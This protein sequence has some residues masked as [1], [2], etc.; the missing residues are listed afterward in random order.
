MRFYLITMTLV[1]VVSDYLLHPFYPQFF[2]LAFGITHPLQ[3]GYYFSA[4]C[5]MVMIAFPFWA[6]VALKVPELKILVYTQ[7]VAGILALS[8]FYNTSYLWFWILSLTMIIFK[9]S[10]LLVYP[11]ILRIGEDKDHVDTIGLLSVIVH[12]G[13]ILGA[14]AGGFVVE[15]M[16][17]RYI[18][19]IMA[20]GD[21]VQ[22]LISLYLL[23]SKKFKPE[24]L[25]SEAIS[26]QP[27]TGWV[28][29]GFVM[30]LGLITLIL[31]FGYFII[32][33]FFSRYWESIS[34]YNSKMVSGFVYAVPG[35]V[36]LLA[37]W[38]NKRMKKQESSYHGILPA[39]LWS[40]AGLF[41]QA[42]GVDTIVWLGRCV[43][44]WGIFQCLVRF[45]ALLFDLSTPER[46]AT[47]YS[48]IHFFQNLGVL[49][50][51]FAAGALV[52]SHGLRLPFVVALGC[53]VLVVLL[54]YAAFKHKLRNQNQLQVSEPKS[55]P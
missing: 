6:W 20:T 50:A 40:L 32:S 38:L 31:Y 27:N 4:I 15:F 11:Y 25:L 1:A 51:S 52:E 12:F 23:K 45:D 5:F 44:G 34:L 49:L 19:L 54:Y 7:L 17:P 10:Y 13:S 46:Y 42:S 29:N 39:L 48:K 37:L 18:F 35:I 36:A 2:E 21:F 22:M 55:I 16:N 26:P 30:K 3:V 41:L 28:P 24:R 8:C 33:P 53:F 43:Y 47:D 14:I 9:G